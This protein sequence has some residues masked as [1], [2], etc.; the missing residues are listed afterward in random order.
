[1]SNPNSR[2]RAAILGCAGPQLL[3]SERDFFADADPLG[4]ILFE[5]NCRTPDQTREL[6]ESLRACVGRDD[7][8]VLIDQEGGRV[9]RLKPPHWRKLPSA[10]RIGG[11]VARSLDLGREAAYTAARLIAADLEPLGIDVDCAPVLDVPAEG[12]DA[13]IGDRA[14]SN[15]PELVVELGREYCRGLRAGGVLPVI[16]HIPGHGRARVDSHLALPDVAVHRQTLEAIDFVP[17]RA[18]KDAPFA[19]TAHVIYRAYDSRHPA[20]TSPR[21]IDVIRHAIG[22]DGFLMTDDLS[23]KALSGSFADR[24]KAS[25]EAGCDAVLHCN[26]DMAE[27]RDVMRAC[28]PLSD[29]AARRLARAQA[30]R[31]RPD[32][33]D[34]TALAARLDALLTVA[35]A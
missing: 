19:M 4:F 29:A 34:S 12:A 30:M 18:L 15:E 33:A 21:M 8:P 26:A 17:F 32:G 31:T 24:A 9:A 20:T 25:L 23:M 14:F 6:V 5:R 35:A 22:F 16:K 7:A 1:L 28:G 3:E 2:P 10:A 11:L 13:V 27:M